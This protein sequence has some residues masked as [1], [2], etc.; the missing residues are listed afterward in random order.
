MTD[1][2]GTW[3]AQNQ[4]GYE[5]V[6]MHGKKQECVLI[7]DYLVLLTFL[8]LLLAVSGERKSEEDEKETTG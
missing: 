6:I 4:F 3:H 7:C 2:I 5:Q 1:W 8:G